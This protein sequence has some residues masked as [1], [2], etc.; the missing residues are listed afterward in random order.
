MKFNAKLILFTLIL[1][2]LA[3]VCKYFFGPDLN[4]SGF[5][6]VIAIALFAGM[7][8][9]NKNASFLMPLAALL[10]SDIFIHLLYKAGEF[11]YQGFYSGQWKQ[12]LFLLA[13]TVIGWIVKGRRMA[14]VAGG[15]IAAPTLFFLLSNFNVW[16]SQEVLYAKSFQG[17]M[18]CYAAGLPFYKNALIATLVF[19]PVIILLYNYLTRRE[20][21]LTVVSA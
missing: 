3:T 19:L 15:A 2:V 6:P 8:I 21:R 1:A 16:L 7:I 13:C 5:S 10:L 17:L 4:W 9:P 14:A 18:Q 11:E 12:Y 20:A